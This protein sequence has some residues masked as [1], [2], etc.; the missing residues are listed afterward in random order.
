MIIDCNDGCA[1]DINFIN[2]HI[3]I[4][5]GDDYDDDKII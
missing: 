5:D 1:T 2:G 4:D 3:A